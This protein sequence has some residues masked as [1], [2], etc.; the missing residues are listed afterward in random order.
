MGY[1]RKS[2]SYTFYRIEMEGENDYGWFDVSNSG[3]IISKV[4]VEERFFEPACSGKHRE[5]FYS[6]SACG[7]CWQQTGIFGTFDAEIAHSMIFLLSR[8][9]PGR[10]FRVV[11]HTIVDERTVVS[12][13]KGIGMENE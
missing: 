3:A 10:F 2:G 13:M 7:E 9:N 8:Y 1:P 12:T 4:P 5:P 11:K 6:F